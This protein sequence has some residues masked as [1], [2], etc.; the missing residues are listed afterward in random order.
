MDDPNKNPGNFRVLV[1]LVSKHD[2]V[3]R[4]RL[5]D[6]PHNATFL[7]HAIQNEFVQVMAEEIMGKIQQELSQAVYYTII[8]NETKDII[9]KEGTAIN[10]IAI[11]ARWCSS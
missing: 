1:N 9:T 4:K 5:V 8:A 3:V 10:C 2:D 11:S 7:G 6:G